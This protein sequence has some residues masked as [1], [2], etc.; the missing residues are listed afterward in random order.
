MGQP[1]VQIDQSAFQ[2]Y[3][4]ALLLLEKL[5]AASYIEILGLLIKFY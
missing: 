4:L 5:L 1:L 2:A 3:R